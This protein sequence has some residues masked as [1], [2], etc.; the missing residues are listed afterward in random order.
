MSKVHQI[1]KAFSLVFALWTVSLAMGG[2]Q[3]SNVTLNGYGHLQ[4]GQVVKGTNPE[5]SLKD[6]WLASSV[7]GI[8]VTGKPSDR[9]TIITTPELKL[10]YPY[11]ASK[12]AASRTYQNQTYIKEMKGTYVFGDIED[13]IASLQLGIFQ[14]KYNPDAKDFGEY[15]YRTGTYPS[16][17][18]NNFD[19]AQK[20]LCGLNLHMG[21]WKGLEA[22]A[23]A[24]SELD[25]WPYHDVSLGLLAGYHPSKVFDIGAGIVFARLL[26]IREQLTSPTH[27]STTGA[28]T[29]RLK[30]AQYAKFPGDTAYSGFY[31]FQGTK[32]MLRGSFAPQQLIPVLD[33]LGK[34]ALKMYFEAAVTALPVKTYP[35]SAHPDLYGKLS[36]FMPVVGGFNLP[37]F[38]LLDV[39]SVEVEYFPSQIPNSYAAQIS[40]NVPLPSVGAII[41]PPNAHGYDPNLYKER[42]IGWA[43]FASKE[44]VKGFSLVGQVAYDHMRV[45]NTNGL[46]TYN[47]VM[48]KKGDWAWQAKAKF[49]Y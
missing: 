19:Y 39:L 6:E 13:P 43:F 37:T 45:Q 29:E 18:I 5:R 23:L 42:T 34:D 47:E 24:T 49:A 32:L 1:K 31:S 22:T 27:T 33:V 3:S 44:L 40:E 8:Q 15:L 2:E 30:G 17:A 41:D 12:T 16:W 35:D 14:F 25:I 4:I 11:I 38:D 28:D 36:R 20:R 26:P 10:L 21:P 9:L 7:L 46:E 48:T